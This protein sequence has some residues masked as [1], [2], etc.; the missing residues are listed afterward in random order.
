VHILYKEF[1][2]HVIAYRR[3]L[4][5]TYIACSCS[6]YSV[7]DLL[8]LQLALALDRDLDLRVIFIF[9]TTV[10]ILYLISQH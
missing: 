1:Q 5:L 2:L 3:Y 6:F 7:F 4:M 10:N 9:Y 8:R